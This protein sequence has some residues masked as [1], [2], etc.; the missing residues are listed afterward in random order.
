MKQGYLDMSEINL[1]ICGENLLIEEEALCNS[2]DVGGMRR[3]GDLF[4]D[5]RLLLVEVQ[6]HDVLPDGHGGGYGAHVEL[7]DVAD[8]VLLLF[9]EKPGHRSRL[10]DGVEVVRRDVV[11]TL[12]GK[13]KSP[14]DDVSQ[15]ICSILDKA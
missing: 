7:E 9:S 5:A 14:A 11:P 12:L 10:H 4:L 6:I 1:S 3:G 15:C 13:P 2:Y 8:Q